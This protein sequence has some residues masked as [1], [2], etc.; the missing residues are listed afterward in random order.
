MC[1]KVMLDGQT[2]VTDENATRVMDEPFFGKL[3]LNDFMHD[4]ISKCMSPTIMHGDQP[5]YQTIHNAHNNSITWAKQSYHDI[6][7]MSPRY[8]QLPGPH[9]GHTHVGPLCLHWWYL[10][11]KSHFQKN[12]E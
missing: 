3:G 7:K 8:C 12:E 11:L 6:S 9:A 5:T 4:V 10:K 2:C 1:D